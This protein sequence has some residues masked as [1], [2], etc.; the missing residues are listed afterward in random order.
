MLAQ[1]STP[2][3]IGMVA[4][5]VAVL[6][7]FVSAVFDEEVSM[8]TAKPFSA[9]CRSAVSVVLDVTGAIVTD[10]AAWACQLA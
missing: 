6:V 10:V 1:G 9:M 5:T 4:L 3:F 2:W 8:K 7:K